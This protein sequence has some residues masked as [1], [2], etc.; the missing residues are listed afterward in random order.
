M[1]KVVNLHRQDQDEGSGYVFFMCVLA[2]HRTR[3]A[4]GQQ[5][6]FED[7]LLPTVLWRAPVSWNVL[8]P[9]SSSSQ[10]LQILIFISVIRK[11]TLL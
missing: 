2:Q 4:A 3:K 7:L 10:A 11:M 5:S 8:L 9:F 6:V 1:S